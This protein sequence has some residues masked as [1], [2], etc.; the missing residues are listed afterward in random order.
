MKKLMVLRLMVYVKFKIF[1]GNYVLGALILRGG[2]CPA[3]AWDGDYLIFFGDLIVIHIN[4]DEFGTIEL[5]RR[6]MQVSSQSF[7]P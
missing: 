4:F 2:M 7:P 5:L 1:T 3:V 6:F